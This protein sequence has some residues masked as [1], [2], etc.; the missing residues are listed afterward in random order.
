M[1]K[2]LQ[3]MQESVAQRMDFGQARGGFEFGVWGLFGFR[4]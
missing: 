2:S 1:D 4:I 3:S